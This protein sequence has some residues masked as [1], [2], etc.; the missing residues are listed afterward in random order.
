VNNNYNSN[1]VVK[2][3]FAVV[4]QVDRRVK[5]L[6]SNCNVQRTGGGGRN[7]TPPPHQITL[8]P[9]LVQLWISLHYSLPGKTKMASHFIPVTD[10]QIFVVNEAAVS[11]NTK[12]ATKFCL[13]VCRGILMNKITKSV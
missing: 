4:E 11:P 12:K 13:T 1:T 2:Q 9:S 8:D 10:E 3:D 5:S 7:S 6:E